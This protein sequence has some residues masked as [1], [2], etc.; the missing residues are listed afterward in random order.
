[1]YLLYAH[2]GNR[3]LDRPVRDSCDPFSGDLDRVGHAL[4]VLDRHSV[5]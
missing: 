2:I 4:H 5:V 3:D 1:M